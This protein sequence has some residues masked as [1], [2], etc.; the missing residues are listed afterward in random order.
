MALQDAPQLP[1]RN[2]VACY[3]QLESCLAKLQDKT[4]GEALRVLVDDKLDS[5]PMPGGGDTLARWRCLARVAE[6]DLALAKLYE[7]HTDALAILAEFEKSSVNSRHAA[8]WSVWAADPPAERLQITQGSDDQLTLNGR[9]A[10]CSGAASIDYALCTAWRDDQGPFLV[11][12]A[13]D[14]PGISIDTD[15]WHAVGMARSGTCDVAFQ[16]ALAQ[17]VGS[18][19]GYLDRPGFWHGGAGIAACWYGGTIGLAN[20]LWR[21]SSCRSTPYADAHLGAVDVALAQTAALLRETAAAIDQAPQSN[22]Q[23]LALRCRAS[24]EATARCV[25]NHVGMAL[26]AAPYCRDRQFARLAADL[27]VFI[28]QS[29]ADY[30]FAALATT[31]KQQAEKQLADAPWRL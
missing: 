22:L 9:K 21:H 3:P 13:L 24:A 27:P 4:P 25:L 2:I 12:V 23:A 5:L 29:H 20:A 8:L 18:C 14:Q 31:L 30:D 1:G 19:K 11:A 26:G 28:R 10:W 17:P 15:R 16:D 6:Q 7:G